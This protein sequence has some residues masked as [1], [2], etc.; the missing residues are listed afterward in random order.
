MKNDTGLISSFSAWETTWEKAFST[1]HIKKDASNTPHPILAIDDSMLLNSS[2]GN[3]SNNNHPLL[4][5]GTDRHQRET[6][7]ET[8]FEK[9]DAPAVFLAP[10]PMLQ[11]FS[12][13]RQ[14]V[15]F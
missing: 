5:P 15:S 12:M 4:K 6:M 1:L 2:S 14:T 9:W 8:F 3:S 7:L 13:G 10:S 11:A